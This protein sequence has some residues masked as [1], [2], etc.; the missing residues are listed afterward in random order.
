MV[1]LP[2]DNYRL[3]IVPENID[4][5]VSI[6]DNNI[7]VT[8]NLVKK[9]ETIEKD[10]STYVV[11]NYIYTLQNIQTGH[12]LNVIVQKTN[13][14]FLKQNSNWIKIT[15][16]F[17]KENNRWLSVDDFESLFNDETVYIKQ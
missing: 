4:D 10:G 7:D 2:G 12:T 11:V 5:V 16:V 13:S 8:N 1:V 9:Q 17:V 6:A 14:L 3:T 15:K